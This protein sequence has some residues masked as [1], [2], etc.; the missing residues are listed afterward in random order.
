MRKTE[1]VLAHQFYLLCAK[2]IPVLRKE[3][4]NAVN[5]IAFADTLWPGLCCK[6]VVSTA[7]ECT[8]C[9]VR[10]SDCWSTA[11]LSCIIRLTRQGDEREVGCLKAWL[12][13]A[14]DRKDEGWG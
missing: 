3:K 11:G 14:F 6:T 13:V 9:V 10:E 2:Q 4:E 7:T 1:N 8:F 5:V 12:H